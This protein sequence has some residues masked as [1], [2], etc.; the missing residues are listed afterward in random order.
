MAAPT[1]LFT[2][3]LSSNRTPTDDERQ[4]AVS[5][6]QIWSTEAAVLAAKVQALQAE[7]AQE[8]VKLKE[9][10]E[11]I[12]LHSSIV[13]PLRSVPAEILQHIFRY[14]LPESHNAL[15]SPDE[16]PIILTRVCR[17]WRVVAL[18]TPELWSSIHIVCTPFD[19]DMPQRSR[20]IVELR[21]RAVES[22]LARSGT[23]LLDISIRAETEVMDIEFMPF[24]EGYRY[25]STVLSALRAIIPHSRR[26]S[27]LS[28]VATMGEL[29]ELLPLRLD[30]PEL[31]S[32][33]FRE[34]GRPVYP[35]TDGRFQP[36]FLSSAQKLQRA[37]LIFPH[38]E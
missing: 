18:S 20:E 10:Q 29:K 33:V 17:V 12:R 5:L 27:Q 1:V 32:F 6:L 24:S 21:L 34:L 35:G 38:S 22:W 3:L 36:F 30:L 28:I 37:S 13:S 14:T 31:Q 9:I 26:W 19:K 2:E 23:C 8:S 7:L 4:E 11:R 16:A 15:L 25:S